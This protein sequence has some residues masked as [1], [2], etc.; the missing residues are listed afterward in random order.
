M[1][2][3]GDGSLR[4]EYRPREHEP[5]ADCAARQQGPGHRD[6]PYCSDRL[7][8]ERGREARIT[9]VSAP[10]GLRSTLE[11]G[12]PEGAPYVHTAQHVLPHR[13]HL[14]EGE[15]DHDQHRNRS[16]QTECAVGADYDRLN[17][18]K[19]NG[20]PAERYDQDEEKGDHPRHCPPAG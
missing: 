9:L 1:I 4:A 11:E 14:V 8:R 12:A 16:D 7:S 10:R 15:W 2:A 6:A 5:G 19:E 18:D 17:D 3:V 20:N 13:H